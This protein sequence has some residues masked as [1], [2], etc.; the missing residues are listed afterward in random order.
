MW[1][2]FTLCTQDAKITQKTPSAH[3]RTKL[4]NYIFANKARIDNRKTLVEQQYLH[5]SSQ[6]GELRPTNGWDW[7]TSLGQH[8]KY[9]RVSRLGFVPTSLNGG[10]P[11]FARCCNNCSAVAELGDRLAT[12]DMGRKL[13]GCVPLGGA[14]SPSNTMSPGPT[15]IRTEW[16]WRSTKLFTMFGRFLP[17]TL[18]CILGA[19]A[20]TEFCQVQNALCVQVLRSPILAALLHRTRAVGVSQTLRCGTRNGMTE[21]SLL[22]F[23]RGRHLYFDSGH[24]VIV[25]RSIYLQ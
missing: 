9:Q 3:H 14:R 13:E 4:S 5:M 6:Y 22:I 24:H 10:Q 20:L 7:L 21:L 15:P 19:L 16:R 18:Y 1:R 17:A 12:T 23:N 2:H 8:S 25:W 11:N